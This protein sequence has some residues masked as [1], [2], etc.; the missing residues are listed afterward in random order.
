MCKT[1]NGGWVLVPT[2]FV[3]YGLLVDV[4]NAKLLLPVFEIILTASTRNL[5]S[6]G[7]LILH[8]TG[9]NFETY[10][11]CVSIR[12]SKTAQEFTFW[13]SHS[14]II[15]HSTGSVGQSEFILVS[16]TEKR[17]NVL[18]LTINNVL[19]TSSSK[20]SPQLAIPTSGST[21]INFY[22]K[23]M[24]AFG[25]SA[26]VRIRLSAC[27]GLRWT[28]ESAIVCKLAAGSGQSHLMYVSQKCRTFSFSNSQ[29]L[30]TAYSIP[31]MKNFSASTSNPLNI[32]LH[33]SNL[34]TFD[35]DT[36]SVAGF[37][38]AVL[39][40][41]DKSQ[42]LITSD[43]LLSGKSVR[44]IQVRIELKSGRLDDTILSLETSPFVGR[45]LLLKSQ[46]YGCATKEDGK[47][48]IFVFSDRAVTQP[49]KS[50]CSSGMYLPSIP[51]STLFTYSGNLFLQ[52]TSG[53]TISTIF[54]VSITIVQSEINVVADETYPSLNIKWYSDSALEFKFP[55]IL[56][57]NHTFQT[58]VDSQ[59]S[60]KMAGLH[61][62]IPVVQR[63]D[64]PQSI[65]VT[66]SLF[67]VIYGSFFGQRM[68][69]LRM[70]MGKSACPS[71]VWISD[72]AISGKSSWGLSAPDLWML[73]ATV[74]RQFSVAKTRV[75]E[76]ESPESIS[77]DVVQGSFSTGNVL[78][79][80]SGNR[81]GNTQYSPKLRFSK[82]ASTFTHWKSDSSLFSMV[83]TK[84]KF[85]AS[86][87]VSIARLSSTSGF[88]V[89]MSETIQ[90]YLADTCVPRSGSSRILLTGM[91]FMP[92]SFSPQV[93]IG[94]SGATGTLWTSDSCIFSQVPRIGLGARLGV[95][96]T[97]P[98]WQLTTFLP[99][100]IRIRV[101]ST[102]LYGSFVF[103]NRTVASSWQ[104]HSLITLQGQNFGFFDSSVFKSLSI[105]PNIGCD[106]SNW[107]SD[108]SFSA[109]CR[110]S[111][112]GSEV[113]FRLSTL[114]SVQNEQVLHW[115]F[116]QC[117]FLTICL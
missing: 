17:S 15:A 1:S 108:S 35:S 96:V 54:S 110:V 44:D 83:A 112:P 14:S 56:G 86:I 64:N 43:A 41:P 36:S 102:Q 42:I 19:V 13:I 45:I 57:V 63:P 46:C 76:N 115:N 92:F 61:Y 33:G 82:S 53:S 113:V 59:I 55:T 28:S 23:C 70:R 48:L 101:P 3:S 50:E 103:Q 105:D 71:S 75:V 97:V 69:T 25:T 62:P 117:H 114:Q 39:I 79:F 67:A 58:I 11:T 77:S 38:E 12:V 22:G 109:A 99:N 78:F 80:L 104:A 73:S 90:I 51:F 47:N 7:S 2:T 94:Q 20:I 18:N 37:S 10:D 66:G 72:V 93:R 65:P 6:T 9:A 16:C 91:G 107:I 8:T 31:I 98:V 4:R 88:S 49:P 116:V 100:S 24:G 84:S 26:A 27:N 21:N 40:E 89:A 32:I 81:F 85:E 30:R 87:S 106:S 74:A 111:P 68:H 52:F 95:H 5:P 29:V 60:S 34:A